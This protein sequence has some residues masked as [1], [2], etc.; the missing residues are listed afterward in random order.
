LTEK[1][2]SKAIFQPDRAKPRINPPPVLRQTF[3][4]KN[5]F[6][7]RAYQKALSIYKAARHSTTST[8]ILRII[9][10]SKAPE[11]NESEEHGKKFAKMSTP[12]DDS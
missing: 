1:I 8:T 2:I 7:P 6:H 9:A 11:G 12:N 3:F 10:E 5:I 4:L